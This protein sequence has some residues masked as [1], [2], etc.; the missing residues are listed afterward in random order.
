MRL[1]SRIIIIGNGFDIWQ[2]L[3]TYYSEFKKYYYANRDK[4]MKRL[5]IRKHKIQFDD[6]HIKMVG[7]VELIYGDTFD[8]GELDHSFWNS[9]EESLNAVDDERI[10]LFFG[11]SKMELYRL[12]KSVKN[13]KRVLTE[14]FI[15]WIKTIEI[16]KAETP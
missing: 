1:K 7:D 8:P 13:A 3:N 4:I 15:Q 16:D 9:F 6:G 5:F 14:A 11:K 10:N 12:S 2:G